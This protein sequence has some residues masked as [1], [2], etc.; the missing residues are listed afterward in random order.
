MNIQTAAEFTI[1]GLEGINAYRVGD[2][3][4]VSKSQLCMATRNND[5]TRPLNK[6]L[7]SAKNPSDANGSQGFPQGFD[8]AQIEVVVPRSQ[9]GTSVAH[10][11]SPFTAWEWLLYELGNRSK[12]VR[13]R[14]SKLVSA[15]GAVGIDTMVKEACGITFSPQESCSDWLKRF[16][17]SEWRKLTQSMK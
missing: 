13:S 15:F 11:F 14:A 16:S 10:L 4:Y 17:A 12:E 3:G 7:D 8:R 2:K 9:G 5:D 1:A 6:W